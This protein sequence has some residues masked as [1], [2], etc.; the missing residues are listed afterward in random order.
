EGAQYF[1]LTLGVNEHAD[2]LDKINLKIISLKIE[3]KDVLGTSVEG[4]E[5]RLAFPVRTHMQDQVHTSRIPG[6]ATSKDGTLLAIY[7][8]RYQS[9][10]DLQ[11]HMDI[12]VQRSFD[13]GQT[14]QPMQIALDMKTWGDLPEKFNG[15]SDACILV[16]QNSGAIYIAGLWSHGVIN[17]QGKWIE[18]LSDTSTV[19]NHQWKTRGSQPGFDVKETS[20]F[21]I[22]K[23]TDDGKT[24]S[25]PVN[26]TKQGKKE[27]W[28]LWAPAPGQGITMKDGTLV[29]PTQG[30]D[31]DGNP[32]SYIT[33]SKNS[34][35]K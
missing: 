21:L 31:K 16:D 32:F 7:D 18:G 30:R 22:T 25:E 33:Y 17:D 34:G 9:A 20:Q 15:V 3:D 13:K 29:F 4:H 1:W 19:W 6:L 10:R 11:G 14:W 23:S 35:K 8:A 2:L 28:W 12:A 5:Y 26:I 27:E 24:W